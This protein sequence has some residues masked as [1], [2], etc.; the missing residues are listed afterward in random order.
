MNKKV[1]YIVSFLVVVICVLLFFVTRFSDTTLM[2]QDGYFV[3]GSK[4]DSVLMSSSKNVKNA[5]VDLEKMDNDDQILSNLGKYYITKDDKKKEINTDYPLYTNNGL[6]IVN[7][8]ENNT[9]INKNFETF[10]SYE[11]FTIT[12]GK[13]YNYA[14]STQADVED[15]IFLE[16]ENGMDINLVPLTIQTRTKEII[17]PVN[18]IINFQEG[19]FRYYVYQKKGE[20]ALKKI[21]S[22]RLED[23]ISLLDM[24]MTYEDLLIGLRRRSGQSSFIESIPEEYV[25]EDEKTDNNTTYVDDSK[26]EK[27]YQ[28]PKVSADEF[29]PSI[30]M[31]TSSVNISDPAGVITGG[32]N[33]TFMIGDKIFLRKTFVSSGNI[34]V[35]GLKP[36]TEYMVVG[37]FR[38]YN[39]EKKKVEA[40]FLRQTIKTGDFKTL[41]PVALSFRNGPIY[42]NHIEIDELKIASDI[43]SEAIIGLGKAYVN[44]NKDSFGISTSTIRPLSKGESVVYVSPYN[45]KSNTIVKYSFA[46]YDSWGNKLNVKDN[47]GE[48]RTSKYMPEVEITVGNEDD[49]RYTNFSYTLENPDDVNIADFRYIVYDKANIIVGEGKL[50]QSKEQDKF[51]VRNLDPNLRHTIKFIGSVDIED[52]KGTV[53]TVLGQTNFATAPIRGQYAVTDMVE[54]ITSDSAKI[55]F[56]ID[57]NSTSDV[58]MELLS[59]FQVDIVDPDGEIVHSENY[60]DHLEELRLGLEFVIDLEGL[61]SVTNYQIN[62]TAKVTQGRVTQNINTN[63]KTGMFK[64]H[65]KTAHA[66][67]KNVFVNSFM[68]DFDVA[69]IDPDG[70]ILSERA[71]L[72]LREMTPEGNLIAYEELSLNAEYKQMSYTKLKPNT[73][74]YLYFVAETYN[75]EDSNSGFK[76]PKY[77]DGFEEDGFDFEKQYYK[78]NTSDKSLYGSIELNSLVRQITSKNLFDINDFERIGK[79]KADAATI[80]KKYNLKNNEIMF[81]SKNG[82]VNFSYYV[83]EMLDRIV[84]ISFDAKYDMNLSNE[85]NPAPVSVMN[86]NKNSPGSN[87]NQKLD[88]LSMDKYSKQGKLEINGYKHFSF[89][90]Y[91]A[92]PY[93]GFY[94]NAPASVNERTN[95][96]FR[97][98]N[99]VARRETSEGDDLSGYPNYIFKDPVM[100]S[101]NEEIPLANNNTKHLFEEKGLSTSIGNLGDGY[102]RITDSSGNVVKEFNYVQSSVSGTGKGQ[103]FTPTKGDIYT[104][105]LWG[106]SGG[107]GYKNTDIDNLSKTSHG[108]RGAYTSGKLSIGSGQTLYFFIGGSGE[109]GGTKTDNNGGGTA[110]TSTGSSGGGATDVR[111]V[112]NTGTTGLKTR[113]MVAAGGGGADDLSA[114]D[115]SGGAGGALVS[116]GAY[117]N[118]VLTSKFRATQTYSGV[119]VSGSLF[120][121][122]AN[123]TVNTDSGGGGAGWYGG[124]TTNVGNGGGAGGSSYIS[125]YNGCISDKNLSVVDNDSKEYSAFK[126]KNAFK[127]IFKINV[128][129]PNSETDNKYYVRIYE[130]G[131]EVENSPFDFKLN[132]YQAIDEIQSFDFKKARNYTVVLCVKMYDRFYELSSYSFNTTFE[133]YAITTIDEF[134]NMF[135]NAHYVVINDLDFTTGTTIPEFYG[136]VDFQ[137]HTITVHWANRAYLIQN[138]RAGA[139][140][141]NVVIDLKMDN[142]NAVAY[143]SSIAQYNYGKIDNVILNITQPSDANIFNN[144][145]G[146]VV[147]YNYG[148]IKNF[149]VHN[150]TVVHAYNRMGLV[151]YDNQGLITNGMLYG[152]D[153]D[154]SQYIELSPPDKNTGAISSYAEGNSRITNVYSLIAIRRESARASEKIVGNLVGYLRGGRMENCFSVEDDRYTNNL[155]TQDPNIGYKHGDAMGRRVYYFSHRTYTSSLSTKGSYLSLNDRKFLN[156]LINTNDGFLVDEYLSVGYYPHVLLNDCMPN[157][158]MIPLPG[159]DD[160]DEIDVLSTDEISNDGDSAVVVLHMNNPS[161]AKITGVGIQDLQKVV[162][163]SQET[164]VGRTDLTVEVSSPLTY[165]SIYYLQEIKYTEGDDDFELSIKFPSQSKPIEITMYHV[166]KTLDDWKKIRDGLSDNYMLKADLDFSG[167]SDSDYWINK[168]F[169]G[170]LEGK[171]H[172]LK[173]IT[174]N[175]QNSFISALNGS[176]IIRNLNVQNIEKTTSSSHGSF[177]YSTA[178]SGDSSPIIDNVHINGIKIA[179]GGGYIGGLVSQAAAVTIKNCSVSNMIVGGQD[180]RKQ[181]YPLYNEPFDIVIGGIAGSLTGYSQV[182]NSFV[183]NIKIDAVDIFSSIG[184]GGIFGRMENG[185]IS[186]AYSTG[187]INTINQYV[188]GIGGYSNAITSNVW[189]AVTISSRHDYIGGIYGYKANDNIAS[190]LTLGN[191]YDSFDGDNVNLTTGNTLFIP[192]KNFYWEKQPFNG[193]IGQQAS[194]EKALT[195]EQ[196]CNKET[197]YYMLDFGDNFLYEGVEEGRVPYLRNSDTGEEIPN[198]EKFYLPHELFDL[199]QDIEVVNQTDRANITIYLQNPDGFE[200]KSVGFDY[201]VVT[202]DTVVQITSSSPG[203]TKIDIVGIKFTRALDY[204][205][206][207]N[208]RYVDKKGEIIDYTKHIRIQLQFWVEISS[209]AKWIEYFDNTDVCKYEE[210]IKLLGDIDFAGQNSESFTSLYIS[211]LD[212]QGHKIK[213]LTLYNIRSS[214]AMFQ[215]VNRSLTNVT[216]ENIKLTTKNKEGTYDEGAWKSGKF[217]NIVRYN[218]GEISNINFINLDFDA[219]GISYVA[220][221]GYN[222]GSS[223]RNLMINNKAQGIDQT[224]EDYENAEA[225]KDNAHIKSTFVG[226]GYVA[227]IVAYSERDCDGTYFE[228]NNVTIQATGSYVG[229]LVGRKVAGTWF[230]IDGSNMN[231]TGL[232]YVGG[233]VGEC[234]CSYMNIINSNITALYGGTRIGGLAGYSWTTSSNLNAVNIVINSAGSS[235]IGGLAGQVAGYYLTVKNV[236]I[237]V[238]CGNNCFSYIG[239]LAGDGRYSHHYAYNI[240]INCSHTD[241]NGVIT[242]GMAYVGGM[243]GYSEV[244]Y[245]YLEHA[246]IDNQLSIVDKDTGLPK[247]QGTGGFSGCGRSDNYITVNDVDVTSVSVTGGTGGIYGVVTGNA[248]VQHIAGNRI[249]VHGFNYVGG[250]TGRLDAGTIAYS[251]VSATVN[252]SGDYAGGVAGYIIY[253][254]DW[255]SSSSAKI[256]GVVLQN[257][258]VISTG[259]YVALFAGYAPGVLRDKFF[260]NNL[261]VGNIRSNTIS[262]APRYGAI[263]P[264]YEGEEEL[265]GLTPPPDRYVYDSYDNEHLDNP[266]APYSR[267]YLYED[268]QYNLQKANE[269]PYLSK[270]LE[271]AHLV[272]LDDIKKEDEFWKGTLAYGTTRTYVDQSG[273]IQ[274]LT[275]GYYPL[276]NYKDSVDDSK[277]PIFSK[278][279]LVELPTKANTYGIKSRYM[280]GSLELT[281]LDVYSSGI[282]TVN[283]EFNDVAPDVTMTVYEDGKKVYSGRIESRVYTFGYDYQSQIKVLLTGGFRNQKEYTYE[284]DDLVHKVSTFDNSYA[285]IHDGQLKGNISS[286]KITPIH[287]YEDLVLADDLGIYDLSKGK[288]TGY[289]TSTDMKVKSTVEP[290][291]HFDLGVTKIDT[292]YNYSV[293]HKQDTD[294]VYEGQLFFQNGNLELVDKYLENDKSTVLVKTSGNKSYVTVLGNDGSLHDLKEE[295]SLPNDFTNSGIEQMSNNIKNKGNMVV[296]MYTSGRVVV[297]DFFTGTQKEVEKATKNVSFIQYMKENLKF[298]NMFGTTSS[299]KADYESSKELKESLEKN[300][301]IQDG[302]GDYLLGEKSSKGE[303]TEGKYQLASNYVSYYNAV[304]GDYEVVNLGSVVLGDEDEVITENNKIYTSNDLVEFYMK[305]SVIDKASHNVSIVVLLGI[306]LF[307]VLVALGM[308]FKNEK[309]KEEI[310]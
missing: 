26:E 120:G 306:V 285:Y 181:K 71:I 242:G 112:D 153:I 31:A 22:I 163:L 70:A 12:D 40:E 23:K 278:Q 128:N 287:I 14:D 108:G 55:R 198:Q 42:S 209:F 101:G 282:D 99:V 58:L 255:V 216:F 168:A 268:N 119:D 157:Q 76:S 109:Y 264:E 50:D 132:D 124:S 143:Y 204:Y 267:I 60:D 152:C 85:D 84:T 150:L 189:S 67:I 64:T 213:N 28:Q 234:V 80:Y 59:S 289:N 283:M 137:G 299:I 273:K 25:I 281:T 2:A 118:G 103:A 65:K 307:S 117:I 310:I 252:A 149:V 301:I 231:I 139:V 227:G 211:R 263:L 254:D 121:K 217:V 125:G 96:W 250:I 258:E 158:D 173:N 190:T 230:H 39:E 18:S 174:L 73:D 136:E 49:P 89:T 11:N 197:Y 155:L 29:K 81:G 236:D 266:V 146:G 6:A 57:K 100:K 130:E 304:R 297:F 208:I 225:T 202:P 178:K 259:N 82:W 201:L 235:Y 72:E 166:I 296:V 123:V 280:L 159:V 151:S 95:V 292:F 171:N 127:G 106:A 94:I 265:P 138:L 270:T 305:E 207:N 141:K 290:L 177:I 182:L 196:L 79:Q 262:S 33:F 129:D 43:N 122:G 77:L 35:T 10:T 172:T 286:L 56:R 215:K 183:Q 200:I 169:T 293:I 131:I 62:Y 205:T 115:G 27:E 194:A 165:K 105:E 135:P 37:S 161:A 241:E 260:Y 69:I 46:L 179:S 223:L 74:Y 210:N 1:L 15:Y 244:S 245:A 41:D 83:P 19:S 294:V 154:V 92:T 144:V 97:N 32:V 107:D 279:E 51:T 237:N 20:L 4:V 228:G 221:I 147:Y 87:F 219:P 308:A 24:E 110:K 247:Y 195:T 90:F 239:G 272:T 184:I 104:I 8:N 188:G 5:D 276:L 54:D 243:Y 214:F 309:D 257:V 291:F 295:I 44:V 98:I 298:S 222:R 134:Y 75:E 224:T 116:E 288:I 86:F 91:A 36:N 303:E 191:V 226:D 52:G 142:T 113:I 175:H 300:P 48:T 34:Q 203:V 164:T 246:I 302:N 53:E 140:V 133:I 206:L 45:L 275:N 61:E 38:Y 3:S 13:M 193:Y 111:V 269:I 212:G 145:N 240:D 160:G 126:A 187:Y 256:Y 63:C 114:D 249:E 176:G 9:L 274:L 220:P 192:Q 232:S 102:A 66:D 238:D 78:F 199:A 185:T 68:L 180:E 277:Y 47:K 251:Q 186:N 170:I 30:Y 233:L 167:Y 93:I 7:Y 148:T 17:I 162:I 253:T 261:L 248:T 156:E 21:S 284:P 271:S 88:G 229:G 16:M 218:Y